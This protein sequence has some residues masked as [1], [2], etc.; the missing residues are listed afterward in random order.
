MDGFLIVELV[1]LLELSQLGVTNIWEVQVRFPLKPEFFP[2]SFLLFLELLL[3]CKDH[4]F[5]QFLPAGQMKL[6][7][8]KII[9]K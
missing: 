1:E 9:I 4:S 6:I 3:T 8:L 7:S 5:I 2:A